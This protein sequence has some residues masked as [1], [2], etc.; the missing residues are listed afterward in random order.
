MSD[1]TNNRSSDA[2]AV[3]RACN[4]LSFPKSKEKKALNLSVGVIETFFKMREKAPD[5]Q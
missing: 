2:C 3:D 1:R 4:D 5:R